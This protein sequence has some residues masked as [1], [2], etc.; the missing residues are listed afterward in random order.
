MAN[1]EPRLHLICYDIA[2]PRRL[3]RVHRY[4]RD[5][6]VPVQYSVFMAELTRGQLDVIIKELK[7]RIN[8]HHDDIRIY[9][10]P[11]VPRVISL[12][13]PYFPEGIILVTCGRGKTEPFVMTTA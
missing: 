4:L 12:G 1:N 10:L 13:Q 6:A 9:P 11:R 3:G 2:N 7:E 5:H 8:C